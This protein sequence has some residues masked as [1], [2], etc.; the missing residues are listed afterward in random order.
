MFRTL[1]LITLDLLC[2]YWVYSNTM[3]QYLEQTIRND[4]P[5]APVRPKKVFQVFQF[6]QQDP[7]TLTLS[8]LLTLNFKR[9]SWHTLAD[10]DLCPTTKD[11]W[12]TV[13]Y[14]SWHSFWRPCVT[15]RCWVPASFW[16]S[17]D[18]YSW[19]A[20]ETLLNSKTKMMCSFSLTFEPV[21][22]SKD[23]RS[24]VTSTLK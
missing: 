12:S 8:S 2:L 4:H 19:P 1:K 20:S 9:R 14:V 16:V 23:E 17:E 13:H 22:W 21:R 11:T 6:I 3:P 7:I 15:A 10:T 24:G 18:T 5:V